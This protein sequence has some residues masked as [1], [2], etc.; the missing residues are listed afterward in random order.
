MDPFHSAEFWTGA[1]LLGAYQFAKFNELRSPDPDFAARSALIPNPR[2]IDFAGRLTYSATLVAF[3]A[4]TFLIYFVL[5]KI[6]PTILSGWAQV[7][8]ASPDEKLTKFVNTVN[9]PLYI[10]AVYM[11]VAQQSIPLLSNIGN[12]QRNLF[13]AWMGIPTKVMRASSFFANQIFA[14]S[15]DAGRLAKEVEVL[16]SD[17]WVERIDAYA[18]AELYATHLAR[19]KLDDEPELHKATRRE[20]KILTRQLVD[21]ASLATVRESGAASL[22]RLADDLR[23]SMLPNSA[24]PKAF[25]AGGILF[26]VGMT[27]LWNLIP[28][29]D[30]LAAQFLSA[31]AT[32]FWPS[33]LEYSGQYLISQAGPIFLATGV[34]LGTWVSAFGRRQIA[35]LDEPQRVEGIAALFSRFAGLFA[36]VLIGIVLFDICQAF[37]QYGAYGP[38]E[39]TEFMALVKLSLPIYLLHSF[40][41]LFVCFMLLRYMDD[42]VGRMWWKTVPTIAILA[43]GVALASL[44]YAAAQVR[45]QL[46]LPFGTNGVDLAALVII[47][48]VSAAS[49]AF[50]CAALCKRQAETAPDRPQPLMRRDPPRTH[51]RGTTVIPANAS[52]APAAPAGE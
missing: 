23:V 22:S 5:C 14:R 4:A 51:A 43:A 9:Y 46:Q 16:R 31:G 26:L 33:N 42:G 32:D 13:H 37:F 1:A 30:G 35:K 20:L 36:L 29:F 27:F 49:M 40:I 45:H 24:W 2:A 52:L 10:A 39:T 44:S 50:A 28:A 18:D 11:G 6:S 41:A 25:L 17:A 38:G 19:L 7:S 3:L 47:I 8:G 48:N 15:P 12:V 34:A 21:V